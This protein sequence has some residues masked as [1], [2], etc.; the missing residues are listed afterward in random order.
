MIC[1][2]KSTSSM[3]RA[4]ITASL[5]ALLTAVLFLAAFS[6]SSFSTPYIAV[7]KTSQEVKTALGVILTDESLQKYPADKVTRVSASEL[8]VEFEAPSNYQKDP[9]A[10]VTA[11]GVAKSGEVIFA[12]VAPSEVANNASTKAC[13]PSVDTPNS[14]EGKQSHLFSLLEI[15]GSRREVLKQQLLLRLKEHELKE[16]NNLENIFGLSRNKV[17]T[18]ETNIYDLVDRLARLKAA[19]EDMK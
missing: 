18:A 12:D 11:M 19:L 2:K 1:V 8:H 3:N 9:K 4:K 7:L 14:L 15:R 5:K 17:L 10:F 16:L 6:P 13:V